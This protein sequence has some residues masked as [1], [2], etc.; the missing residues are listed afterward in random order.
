M[1]E[2]IENTS[3]RKTISFYYLIHPLIEIVGTAENGASILNLN[4]IEK[5]V[6]HEKLN[7]KF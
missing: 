3:S 7:D 6:I 4:L 5:N 2:F 1:D